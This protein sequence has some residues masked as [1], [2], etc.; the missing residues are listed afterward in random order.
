[1]PIQRHGRTRR[2]RGRSSATDLSAT[3][4]Q[5]SVDKLVN[6]ITY[7]FTV[8]DKTYAPPGRVVSGADVGFPYSRADIK[9]IL[10]DA[11]NLGGEIDLV[12]PTDDAD[13]QMLRDV[14]GAASTVVESAKACLDAMTNP[15]YQGPP[16]NVPQAILNGGVAGLA[17]SAKGIQII[18]HLAWLKIVLND[19]PAISLNVPTIGLGG[20]DVSVSATG[21]LWW[22]HPTFHCSSLCFNW[23]VTW[24]WDRIVPITVNNIKIACSA[25]ANVSAAGTLI[26][27][28]GF[29]DKLRLDYPILRDIPL[30]GFANDFLGNKLIVVFDAG[31]FLATVPVLNSNFAISSV[32]LPPS[33]GRIEA[34]IAIKQI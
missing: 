21:E 27:V 14:L 25:H 7:P 1:M 18:A 34:D 32:Q 26:T 11:G 22:Y 15:S 31:K 20:I 12:V 13:D 6:S 2:G 4:E 17:D 10:K 30:E 23:S 33:Q 19:K 28:Q 9:T 16:R 29:I 8:M 3:I 5:S 24:G